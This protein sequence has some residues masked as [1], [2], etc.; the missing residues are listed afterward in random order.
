MSPYMIAGITIACIFFTVF[1]VMWYKRRLI[2][3]AVEAKIDFSDIS[4]K[5][6]DIYPDRAKGMVLL[7]AGIACMCGFFIFFVVQQKSGFINGNNKSS[8]EF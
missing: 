8:L 4:S 2:F 5:E 6:E 1:V 7:F 3:K